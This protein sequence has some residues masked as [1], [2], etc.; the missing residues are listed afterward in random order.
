M[1]PW[2]EVLLDVV[3]FAGFATYHKQPKKDDTLPR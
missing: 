2:L 3:G 1:S